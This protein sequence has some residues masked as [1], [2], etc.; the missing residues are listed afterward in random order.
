TLLDRIARSSADV[1]GAKGC[2]LRLLN[3]ETGLLEIKASYGLQLDMGR[4][5][6]LKVGESIAGRVAAEGRPVLIGDAYEDPD[7]LNVTGAVASSLVCVPMIA[8]DKVI[9][10]IALYDKEAPGRPGEQP[11]TED[12]LHLLTTLATQASM[13]VENAFIYERAEELA[14]QNE[15]KA[16][17]LA[18]LY[19]IANAMRSTLKLD[20]LLHIIL[21]SMTMGGG[22]GFNR[23]MLFLVNEKTKTLQGMLGV[24]PSSSW[25]AGEI[26]SR[27][28]NRPVNF[29][30]WAITDSEMAAQKES[31]F[32][33]MAKS[34]RISCEDDRGI[35]ATAV[36]EK[37][38]VHVG[39]A[40]ADPVA[41]PEL[42]AM[43]GAREF[44]AVPLVAKD[45]V[46]SLV[47]VD[48][49]FTGR[50]I[51]QEDLRIL[52][53]FANQAGLAIESAMAYSNLEHANRELKEAQD[54]LI[55]TEKLAALGEMA[56]SIAHEIKNPLTV[57][58]GFASR[59]AKKQGEGDEARY[60][61]I[62]RDEAR[63]LEKILGEVLDF[64]REMR[65]NIQPYGLNA[66]AEET[67]SMYE[68]E[69]RE[70]GISAKVELDPD[71]CV[72]MM[73]PQQIKQALIN[74]I[75]NSEQAMEKSGGREIAVST[76]VEKEPGRAVLS[77][78]D[79]G[80]GIPSELIDNIFNP[81]FTTKVTGTGL[82]LAITNKIVKNHGGELE[83]KNREGTGVT[84]IIRLPY[85][86]PVH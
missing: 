8:K 28:G 68:D 33:R 19:D 13:A 34:L 48:N 81:F 9:G 63:R 73:D 39:D 69:F 10:T 84:F 1:I 7:F 38:A 4:R 78:T 14:L 52:M 57:I 76:W 82:G 31:A 83:V 80:G 64:S 50:Q 79:T 16:R 46:I 67:L 51:R 3:G 56:A 47:V 15:K 36:R 44:A 37:R 11:F 75:S 23:A 74:I 54:R 6:D 30:E 41:G 35:F 29:R 49:K 72:I 5:A 42:M 86:G 2:I 43:V 61:K 85:Q 18:F 77:V 20:K 60:A 59:L 21:T 58:G 71:P 62:I 70:K 26:W 40:S 55:Q 32:N 22:L 66:L 12:D 25:E 53:M 45:K 17:E 27:L 24:G 65:P